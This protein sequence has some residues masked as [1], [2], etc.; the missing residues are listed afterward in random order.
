[1]TRTRADSDSI[2][3]AGAQELV[4]AHGRKRNRWDRTEGDAQ[5]C[6]GSDILDDLSLTRGVFVPIPIDRTAARGQHIV[7]PAVKGFPWRGAFHDVCT[8]TATCF[9]RIARRTWRRRS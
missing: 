8:A 9:R 7:F 5:L 1:M 3:Y 2:R 6:A 4:R